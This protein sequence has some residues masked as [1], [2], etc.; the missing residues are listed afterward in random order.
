MDQLTVV[1]YKFKSDITLDRTRPYSFEPDYTGFKVGR[2]YYCFNKNI[3]FFVK[4][5]KLC[6]SIV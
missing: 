1:A 2:R 4:K 3:G 6:V 5:S